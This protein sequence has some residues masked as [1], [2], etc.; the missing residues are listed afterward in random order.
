M[1]PSFEVLNKELINLAKKA[2]DWAG[3]LTDAL[4]SNQDTSCPANPQTPA[5]KAACNMSATRIPAF[6]INTSYRTA[7]NPGA[8]ISVSIDEPSAPVPVDQ[9]TLCSWMGRATFRRMDEAQLLD[10][11]IVAGEQQAIIARANWNL[12]E[13][14]QSAAANAGGYTPNL[15]GIG[16]DQSLWVSGA[17]LSPSRLGMKDLHYGIEAATY[18]DPNAPASQSL[19]E[20]G[21]GVGI[22]PP[23]R[24]S[25][26]GDSGGFKVVAFSG[27]SHSTNDITSSTDVFDV[28]GDGFPDIIGSGGVI[29]TDP[30]GVARCNETSPWNVTEACSRS[31]P[32]QFT[33]PVRKSHSLVGSKSLDISTNQMTTLIEVANA[34]GAMGQSASAK[35]NPQTG[36]TTQATYGFLGFSKNSGESVETRTRDLIDLNGDGLPDEYTDGSNI[37][38]NRGSDFTAVNNSAVSGVIGGRS[39]SSGIGI[40]AGI[41][42]AYNDNSFEAGLAASVSAGDLA[43]TIADINADGLPDM[44]EVSDHGVLSARLNKGVSFS[45]PIDFGTLSNGINN[46]GRTESDRANAGGAYTYSYCICLPFV[47]IYL[48]FNPNASIGGVLTRQTTLFKDIDGDGL[49]DVVFGESLLDTIKH[50]N[51]GISDNSASFISNGLAQ[52]GLLES[53]MQAGNQS[54]LPNLEF[55]Y[56]KS[57][58]TA[59]DPNPRW[60]LAQSIVR[61]GVTADDGPDVKDNSRKTCFSY[62]GGFF[63]RFERR[64]LGYER[65]D[66]VQGCKETAAPIV[67]V[68]D[69]GPNRSKGIRLIERH[70][71]NRTLY[72]AGLM[73]SESVFDISSSPDLGSTAPEEVAKVRQA[74]KRRELDQ[75][76]VLVDTALSSHERIICHNLRTPT[77]E[78]SDLLLLASGFVRNVSSNVKPDGCRETFTAG[79]GSNEPTFDTASRRLTPF[80]VQAVRRTWEDGSDRFLLTAMQADFDQFARVTRNCDLGEIDPTSPTHTRGATCSNISYADYVTPSFAHGATGGGRIIISQRNLASRVEVVDYSKAANPDLTAAYDQQ[81]DKL[82]SLAP[83]VRLRA[84]SYDP[85]SGQ[86]VRSCQF[87]NP[88]DPASNPC[89]GFHHFVR[90]GDALKQSATANVA[91]RSF[92]YDAFG[93]LI[94][95]VGPMGSGESFV[96]KSYKYDPYLSLVA[97]SER[98][99]YCNTIG[100]ADGPK[101]KSIECLNSHVAA[102][103][104]LESVATLIDYRHVIPTL[105]RDINGNATFTPFDGLGRPLSMFVDWKGVVGPP[106]SESPICQLA[107]RQQLINTSATQIASYTYSDLASISGTLSGTVI[108]YS[109]EI[110]YPHADTGT[111]YVSLRTKTLFDNLGNRIQTLSPA[112][113]CAF[114]KPDDMSPECLTQDQFAVSPLEITD[115]LGRAISEGYQATFHV[116]DLTQYSDALDLSKFHSEIAYDGLDRPLMVNLPDGPSSQ[117]GA[118][119]GNAYDFYYSVEPSNSPGIPARH[120]TYA[121]DA[122]CVPTAID[123][124]VR[125]LIRAVTESSNSTSV[126]GVRSAALSSTGSIDGSTTNEEQKAIYDGGLIENLQPDIA[127]HQ[128][129]VRCKQPRG[130]KFQLASYRSE[131]TYNYDALGQLVAVNLPLRQNN[132]K[133][134]RTSILTAYDGLGRRVVI[135]DPDRG[136]EKTSLDVLGN[137]A[138][139]YSGKRHG[140]IMPSDLFADQSAILSS[141]CPDPTAPAAQDHRIERLVQSTYLGG[142][143]LEVSYKLF[144]PMSSGQTKAA[145]RTVRYRYGQADDASRAANRVGRPYETD[146]AAGPITQNF[147]ELGRPVETLRTYN[148]LALFGPNV[149]RPTVHTT[150][151]FDVWGLPKDK[152]ILADIAGKPVKG[153]PAPKNSFDESISYQY[154]I[155]GQLLSE[156]SWSGP[157]RPQNPIKVISDMSYD[158]RGNLIGV[159]YATGV[160][161]RQDFAENSNRLTLARARLAG[162]MTTAT[163][164]ILFQDLHYAYD[165]SGNVIAYEN[166]PSLENPCDPPAE[167]GNCVTHPSLAVELANSRGLL[168]RSSSNRFAYDQLNRIRSSSKTLISAFSPS[169]WDYEGE[170]QVLTDPE[171][172][173]TKNMQLAFNETF[174][175]EATHELSLLKQVQ[176]LTDLK[177]GKTVTQTEISRYVPDAIPLHAPSSIETKLVEQKRT[178][179][180]GF[181]YDAFGRM[182]ADLCKHDKEPKA[183]WPDQYFTWNADDSLAGQVAQIAD[184]RLPE[185][186]KKLLKYVYYNNIQ[187]EFG[188][189][190]ERI[191]KLLSEE[192]WQPGKNNPV[193]SHFVSDTL[194]VD[195]NLTIIRRP[196]EA[197]QAIV[198]YF[199]GDQRLASRWSG[200]GRLF[201]YH[202][203]L[204]TQNVSD[205]VVGLP[206]QPASARIHGQQEY[207]AFGE[208]VHEQE[209][210]LVGNVDGQP[211]RNKPGLPQYRYN[212]KELDESGLQNFGVRFYSDRLAFWL[213]PDPVLHDYLGGQTNVGVLNSRNLAAYTFAWGNPIYYR[214]SDGNAPNA[215]QT[216]T[217]GEVIADI[218]K[219]TLRMSDGRLVANVGTLRGKEAYE[220]LMRMGDFKFSP[221]NPEGKLRIFPIAPVQQLYGPDKKRYIN[222]KEGP[223]DMEHFLSNAGRG[224]K[225]KM[226]ALDQVGQIFTTKLEGFAFEFAQLVSHRQRASAFSPEDMPS[227]ERG[228]DFGTFEFDP[229]STDTLSNQINLYFLKNLVPE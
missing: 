176:A 117:L 17:V 186:K 47:Q 61:D 69:Q 82:V 163:R 145:S 12:S 156:Q 91:M 140:M 159:G 87:V 72:E 30:F 199:V 35:N 125:G 120:R 95:Y 178:R 4:E 53:V 187:S 85:E 11:K 51:L 150:Q 131:A 165:A 24:V 32:P 208:V 227:N 63:D 203:Q 77:T 154:T 134:Q 96:S 6:G 44:L 106:C 129:I 10:K 101:A 168:I 158:Q 206:A 197:P 107:S 149:D 196:G 200:D 225:A 99:D 98:T 8:A 205:I 50:G 15:C 71:A 224:S 34:A 162:D 177:K 29:L 212:A 22:T 108:K 75:S 28:N 220:A 74:Q 167:P 214:D 67:M 48:H 89:E 184:A 84:A 27:N 166:T 3:P 7:E 93:N 80:M 217:L 73:L 114:S 55:I 201:T 223:I 222:T 39:R 138:C 54:S 183:C 31:S 195:P 19:T 58:R 119:S 228:Q 113:L 5:Q 198:N 215:A 218:N 182:Q 64:F 92:Q 190:G 211:S 216:G 174:A 161:T 172:A 144:G 169:Q 139:R 191:Y 9:A 180:T 143:P 175:F 132:P 123:R 213:R 60:V 105:V 104:N 65:V 202:A 14:K 20:P 68:N 57:Q 185:T 18:V 118:R 151:T 128:Q 142:L 127:T 25:S 189:D 88:Q 111:P 226:N 41:S 164:A 188:S 26:G 141:Q 170:P 66:E 102:L 70:Y 83:V 112:E 43:K 115:A 152:R 56:S 124:D 103:G 109:D 194:Y 79:E 45:A 160:K 153:K 171:I 146:D 2:K 207:A 147:D 94:R 81:S 13:T 40:N 181:G 46:F 33:A 204:Q 126:E 122:A 49:P 90:D 62:S 23:P 130:S 193:A 42:S 59:N 229:K 137:A 110:L 52:Y 210:M 36:K 192:T 16:P 136:F 76:Y 148:K 173:R 116:A 78:R 86:M 157:Q 135:D 219:M 121:R 97:V 37:T 221:R 1:L 100:L 133:L 179:T 21:R 209:T 155:G 38:I